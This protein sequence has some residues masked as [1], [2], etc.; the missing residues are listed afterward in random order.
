MVEPTSAESPGFYAAL[1]VFDRFSDVYDRTRYSR[2]PLDWDVVVTDVEGSTKAIEAGR[3]KDVNAAGV[4][5]IVALRNALSEFD[6]PFV[7]GGDGATV[8]TP[9][10]QRERVHTALRGIRVMAKDALGMTMR[11]SMVP[12]AELDASNCEVRVARFGASPNA[13]FAMFSGSG[14]SEAER[15]IKDPTEGPGYAVSDEGP[16]EA[17]FE[18]FECRWKPLESRRGKVVSLLV[19]ATAEDRSEA[20]LAYHDVLDAISA[21]L[22]DAEGRPVAPENLNVA[23]QGRAFNT[24]ARITVGASGGVGVVAR[25]LVIAAQA[26]VGRYGM[27]RGKK[28]LGFPADVYRDEVAAN[29]DFR[30]FDDTL[31]MVLDVTDE[32]HQAL[33]ADLSQRHAAG[34][35]VYGTHIA[36]AALMTCAITSYHGQHMHFVDG[37]DGGYALAAKQLKAQRKR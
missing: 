35:I 30:K 31:R 16:S 7:F 36:S 37:A 25:T 19:Q 33:E 22:G 18:G 20:A 3:Y 29:T 9:A 27:D 12:V 21:L 10:S 13:T 24:E 2:V 8:L 34:S 5:S 32:Q 1:P 26:A 4:A 6:L 23:A 28:T 14:L 11:A 17:S 15:R